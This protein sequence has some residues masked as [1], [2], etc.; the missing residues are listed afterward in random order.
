MR[1]RECFERNIYFVSN[2]FKFLYILYEVSIEKR[3]ENLKEMLKKY[4]LASEV[5][6][7]RY[8]SNLKNLVVLSGFNHGEIINTNE[9]FKNHFGITLSSFG[10]NNISEFIPTE[11]E[12]VKHFQ[13]M[14][15]YVEFKL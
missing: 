5:Q 9:N 6:K 8:E 11:K 10:R 15:E 2:S 12:R 1:L 14:S 7:L 13:L 4:F 3:Y